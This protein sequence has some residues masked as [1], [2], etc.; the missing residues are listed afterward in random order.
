M[1]ECSNEKKYGVNCYKKQQKRLIC[2][3]VAIRRTLV[4]PMKK[5]PYLCSAEKRKNYS[6]IGLPISVPVRKNPDE[7][8][9][10]RTQ[11]KLVFKF[12]TIVF[13][14]A[15]TMII[16]LL[17]TIFGW[18]LYS[19]TDIHKHQNRHVLLSIWSSTY[20]KYSLT[21]SL[22]TSLRKPFNTIAK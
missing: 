17:K 3:T 13:C 15:L 6:H 1:S 16:K 5:L 19:H 4:S 22:M 7:S 14:I 9:R 21:S 8:G 2:I 18:K 10:L 12:D 20:F 11:L